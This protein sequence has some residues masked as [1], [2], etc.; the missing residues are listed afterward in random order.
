[1]NGLRGRKTSMTLR[2]V[3]RSGIVG[4]R[5]ARAGTPIADHRGRRYKR[6]AVSRAHRSASKICSRSGEATGM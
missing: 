1:M 3:R 2:V 6:A 4:C 5:E